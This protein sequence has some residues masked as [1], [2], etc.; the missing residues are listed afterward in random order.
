M[1]TILIFLFICLLL[2]Y[3]LATSKVV[4]GQVPTCNSAHSWWLYS[5]APLGH[6][7]TSTW[8]PTQSHYPNTEPI[9]PCPT[10]TM[11]NAW[12]ESD[13]NKFWSHWFDSS[14]DKTGKVWIHWSSKTG[15]GRSPYFG[16]PSGKN[17]AYTQRIS[18][19]SFVN[20]W[21]ICTT[22]LPQNSLYTMPILDIICN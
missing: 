2:L 4:S 22:F 18:F 15:D 8:Y 6:Q 3:D 5:A 19:T 1:Y 12:L 10:L 20:I 14:R 17:K 9:S 7:A 11:P 13:K 21:L 16:I